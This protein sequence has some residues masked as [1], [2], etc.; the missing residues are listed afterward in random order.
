MYIFQGAVASP[1]FRPAFWKVFRPALMSIYGIHT[2]SNDDLSEGE[3]L[4]TNILKKHFPIAKQ[5][6][7]EDVSG[8]HNISGLSDT[9]E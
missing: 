3:T 7:V 6:L 9:L 2:S 5:I 1:V 4:I 8:R